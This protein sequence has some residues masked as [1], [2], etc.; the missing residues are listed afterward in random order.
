MRRYYTS[1][2][3]QN[4]SCISIIADPVTETQPKRSCNVLSASLES[5]LVTNATAL[6]KSYTYTQ[7]IENY[8]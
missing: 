3:V 7:I 2:Y 5:N 1:G 8:E 4:E 6:S